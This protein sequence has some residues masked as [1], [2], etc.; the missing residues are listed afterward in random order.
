VRHD[1]GF[2]EFFPI[3]LADKVPLMQAVR[4]DL[5]RQLLYSGARILSATGSPDTGFKYAY[6]SD[7]ST[8]SVSIRLNPDTGVFRNMPLPKELEDIALNINVE[9]KW[10]PK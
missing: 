7:K 6:V 2:D 3:K 10:F 5:E 4:H 9:E 1:R 8:G